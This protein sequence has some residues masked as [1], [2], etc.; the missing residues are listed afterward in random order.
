[1]LCAEDEQSRTC[2][3]TAFRLLKVLALLLYH[4]IVVKSNAVRLEL[5][6]YFLSC[7]HSMGLYC[8]RATTSPNRGRLTSRISQRLW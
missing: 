4:F 1:M 6:L 3:M 7:F 8:I 2:W 5:M